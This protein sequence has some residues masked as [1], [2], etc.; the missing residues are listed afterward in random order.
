MLDK[1]ALKQQPLLETIS[2]IDYR[3]TAL[4]FEQR[5]RTVVNESSAR[6]VMMQAEEETD[7]LERA[8]WIFTAGSIA[9][10]LTKNEIIEFALSFSRFSTRT[11]GQVVTDMVDLLE[12][13]IEY[14]G[15]AMN[16]LMQLL[17]KYQD[18]GGSISNWDKAKRHLFESARQARNL[19]QLLTVYRFDNGTIVSYLDEE[20]IRKP[21]FR[22][23]LNAAFRNAEEYERSTMAYWASI[24]YDTSVK[25]KVL[26]LAHDSKYD[27]EMIKFMNW[28]KDVIFN[29][30]KREDNTDSIAY[31]VADYI[32]RQVAT[33]PIIK[34]KK[35]DPIE[36]Q[37]NREELYT[38]A[39]DKLR[40]AGKEF[41]EGII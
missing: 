10:F 34:A 16:D 14:N 9:A 13:N 1:E 20:R 30:F 35:E 22:S 8:L 17:K 12:G 23:M 19:Q 37:S 38:R 6:F 3:I 31:Q 15:H 18:K 36:V 32:D 24:L 28:L 40:K 27:R 7:N 39:K 29:R 2:D 26:T 5:Y 41:I 21:S 33:P 25:S 4:E 11:R